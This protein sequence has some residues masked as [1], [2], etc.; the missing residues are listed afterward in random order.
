M[1][2]TLRAA[3]LDDQHLGRRVRVDGHEGVLR[4]RAPVDESLVQVLLDDGGPPQV[5]TVGAGTPVELL[6]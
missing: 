1:P 5:P 2:D 6:D 3:D 4:A